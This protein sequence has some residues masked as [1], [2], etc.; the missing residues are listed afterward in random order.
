MEPVMRRNAAIAAVAAGLAIVAL[1]RSKAGG[2]GS[3]SGGGSPRAAS[4]SNQRGK[5]S[6]KVDGVFL[7]RLL[8]LMRV[9]VP[10]LASRECAMLVALIS[11][12]LLRTRLTIV[13][14]GIVGGNA[15]YL[16]ERNARKF[17]SGVVDIGLWS[18]PSAIVNSS[19]RYLTSLLEGRFRRNIQHHV[20][21]HYLRQ[22]LVYKVSSASQI[23]H[24]DHRVTSDVSNFCV[25][26]SQIFPLI[27]KPTIDVIV[28]IWQLSRNGGMMPP[29]LMIAYY[30][31]AGFVLRKLMPNF[32]KLTAQTQ[33]K[34]AAFRAVHT[35]I[36][37]HAEEVAFYRGERT[38]RH[39][40]D[41]GISQLVKHQL[42]V[43][44]LKSYTDFMDAVLIKY[45]ATCVGYAVCSIGVF[46]LRETASAAE[47][48]RVY[49]QSSQLYIPLAQAIG[50]LVLLHH[51]ITSL[52][53]YTGRVAE[54]RELL[55]NLSSAAT[56]ASTSITEVP[57]SNVVRFDHA[58]IATPSGDTLIQDLNITIER[59][60]HVLIMGN[61]GSGKTSIIRT[62][63]GLWPLAS[64]RIT[65]PPLT[66]FIV[67]PQR[68][69]LPHGNLRE[70]LIFPDTAE[71]ATRKGITDEHIWGMVESVGLTAVIQREGGLDGYKA[72]HEVLSGGERQ[73]VAFVRVLYHRPAF[74]VLDEATSAV[75]Q[76]IEPAMYEAARKCGTTLI[77]VSHRESLK[78]FHTQLV[79][80]NG[81]GTVSVSDL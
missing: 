79:V 72:W 73:R 28:F 74:A 29:L 53:A 66:E 20:H 58:N 18:L 38:E 71:D 10:G 67:V 25:E 80:L 33:Q 32:A 59:S 12:L 36:I 63:V 17:V 31:V 56:R 39:N 64:G 61:N 50:K 11:L 4:S 24:P 62:L 77:T 45:G 8:R 69:Y 81:D 37:Q 6:V 42:H 51:R 34:E 70:Q 48:T 30:F 68:T 13:M 14:S 27:F 2:T 41:K 23:E 47:R 15:K 22:S 35:N 21:D 46:A 54:L 40:A 3:S 1:N 49:I 16:V 26:V 19:I 78:K 43:K 65:R 44:Q 5:A 9:A 52:A 60:R 76:E 55:A 7:K 57:H 75:S